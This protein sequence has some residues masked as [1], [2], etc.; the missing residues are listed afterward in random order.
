MPMDILFRRKSRL[1]KSF[2]VFV[3]STN[4]YSHHINIA[5]VTFR[6]TLVLASAAVRPA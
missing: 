2:L 5:V 3:F 1:W 6:V 4:K